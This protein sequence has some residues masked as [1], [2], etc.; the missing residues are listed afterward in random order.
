MV[1]NYVSPSIDRSRGRTRLIFLYKRQL[2]FV[3]Q[4]ERASR[5]AGKK[6]RNEPD[7]INADPAAV[8]HRF[9]QRTATSE[10]HF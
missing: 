4:R 2:V 6:D 7:P 1:E 3:T 10:L 9:I 5:V 8:G